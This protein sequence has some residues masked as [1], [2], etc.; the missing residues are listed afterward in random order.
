MARSDSK[1]RAAEN[2]KLGEAIGARRRAVGLSQKQLAE[3]VGV[4][5]VTLSE[6][7]RGLRRPN[8]TK[9]ARVARELGLAVV[10]LIGIAAGQRPVGDLLL[11]GATEIGGSVADFVRG[12]DPTA[13]AAL[14]LPHD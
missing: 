7:E 8:A 12:E 10:E 1:H 9:L 4:H 11:H 5:D 3:K 13:E 6:W 2:V 14:Q